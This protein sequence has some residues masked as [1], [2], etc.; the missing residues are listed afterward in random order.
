MQKEDILKAFKH[1]F[2]FGVTHDH[3]KFVQAF[4]KKVTQQPIE[5]NS[6]NYKP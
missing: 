4:E 1:A 2:K 3:E 6:Y 5:A